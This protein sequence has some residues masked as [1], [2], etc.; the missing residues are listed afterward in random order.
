M[1]EMRLEGIRLE[2]PQNTPVLM[3]REQGGVKRLMPIYI[4][5]PEASSIHYALEGL[6][7]DRP[8][9]HDLLINVVEA[10]D[11]QP[12]KLV[13]TKIEENTYFADLHV[14]Q[15]GKVVKISCRPSDGVA[16]AVR[17]SIPIY[18]E[19][20]LL[21]QVGKVVVEDAPENAEEIIDDFRDFIDSIKPE[22]FQS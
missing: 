9:T 1:I 2:I 18:V 6:K 3:L 15:L 22:D 8:L 7:P 14:L 20:E 4:G 13:I 5:A 10:L 19:D 16:I 17:T 11:A 21:D 12:V